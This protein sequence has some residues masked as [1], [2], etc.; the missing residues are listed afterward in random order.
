MTTTAREH[1]AARLAFLVERLRSSDA[2]AVLVLGRRKQGAP[3][4]S[5]LQAFGFLASTEA[6]EDARQKGKAHPDTQG[7]AAFTASL[8]RLGTRATSESLAL[9]AFNVLTKTEAT[10][11]PA[12]LERMREPSRPSIEWHWLAA[13]E[14]ADELE[15]AA[16]S[17]VETMTQEL[18]LAASRWVHGSVRA[19]VLARASGAAEW[20]PFP[21][22]YADLDLALERGMLSD[23]LEQRR[24]TPAPE[25]YAPQDFA[26]WLAPALDELAPE[27]RV[28]VGLLRLPGYEPGFQRGDSP[29]GPWESIDEEDLPLTEQGRVVPP[30]SDD[31]ATVEHE[32]V[33][34][35]WTPPQRI[36]LAEELMLAAANGALGL[37][38]LYVPHP[39][40]AGLWTL[41]GA[42]LSRLHL[43]ELEV[44]RS[45]VERI[46]REVARNNAEGLDADRAAAALVAEVAERERHA[47]DVWIRAKEGRGDVWWFHNTTTLHELRKL[48]RK[49]EPYPLDVRAAQWLRS[50]GGDKAKEAADRFEG[51]APEGGAA[52]WWHDPHNWPR[53]IAAVLWFDVVRPRLEREGRIAAAPLVVMRDLVLPPSHLLSIREDGALLTPE[54]LSHLSVPAVSVAVARATIERGVFTPAFWRLFGY[55]IH[56]QHEQYLATG[57]AKEAASL[58]VGTISDLTRDLG[59]SGGQ[60]DVENVRAALEAGA[61]LGATR[62][63]EAWRALWAIGGEL[64]Q[65]K[66]GR[67]R[68]TLGPVLHVDA[69]SYMPK[70]AK[71]LAPVLDATR[72]PKPVGDRRTYERQHAAD[73]ALMCLAAER[74]RDGGE[75]DGGAFVFPFDFD[76]DRKAIADRTGL[77]RRSHAD[78]SRRWLDR[79]LEGEASELPPPVGRARF[80]ERADASHLMITDRDIAAMLASQGR[81][82]RGRAKGGRNRAAK[83]PK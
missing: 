49:G 73:Q 57:N 52:G 8:S 22:E 56:G 64:G 12:L 65:R 6:L 43:A 71:L 72:T 25:G 80:L 60:R 81:R 53:T 48:E 41:R 36:T 50:L 1:F 24:G 3:E 11:A 34:Y 61:V 15:R 18:E 47:G 33:W 62:A 35:R 78:L 39:S 20:W 54:G 13:A 70:T 82:R 4:W 21:P 37:P 45:L 40:K 44:R 67:L 10:S 83:L 28:P 9:E 68:V 23:E 76:A 42:A 16:P 14:L 69:G 55:L 58:D 77:Y 46:A 17:L 2:L 26:R 19:D 31:G 5:P 66:R 79:L 38:E 75:L 29:G 30:T 63:G 59:F 7:L 74:S 32:G 27:E 51:E